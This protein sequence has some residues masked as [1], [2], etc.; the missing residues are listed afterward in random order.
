MNW[1]WWVQIAA[2]VLLIGGLIVLLSRLRGGGEGLSAPR[3]MQNFLEE[4]Q[5]LSREFDRV[6]GE[7]RE[8]VGTT[9]AVLDDRVSQMRRMVEDLEQRLNAARE[10]SRELAKAAPPLADKPPAANQPSGQAMDQFRQKVMK[11]ARQG[12]A[13][14][15]IAELTGRPRGEV[16]LVLGLSGR[17]QS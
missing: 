2:D 8:L 1:L 5:R 3:E 11:L 6:L 14:A 7:K 13:P 9:M 17:S 12:K 4:G 10:L 15:Q 16:E